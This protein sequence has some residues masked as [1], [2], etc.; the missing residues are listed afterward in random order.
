MT[1]QFDSVQRDI[2]LSRNYNGTRSFIEIK[3]PVNVDM[4]RE[5]QAG[6]SAV[7]GQAPSVFVCE[8][9]VRLTFDNIVL[10]EDILDCAQ[11]AV[12][13]LAAHNIPSRIV[14][15]DNVN[16]TLSGLVELYA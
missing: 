9:L 8:K 15:P 14:N 16:E 1:G 10:S 12:T 13:Q 5:M 3:P 7:K 4:A 11:F 2:T 6:Y